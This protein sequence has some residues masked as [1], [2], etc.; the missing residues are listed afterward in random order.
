MNPNFRRA[1]D[2]VARAPGAASSALAASYDPPL[3]R[4]TLVTEALWAAAGVT[5]KDHGLDAG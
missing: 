3:E 1:G 4:P 5:Q 2:P